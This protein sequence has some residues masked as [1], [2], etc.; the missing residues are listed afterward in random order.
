LKEAADAAD[1]AMEALTGF[2]RKNDY[3]GVAEISSA[4]RRVILRTVRRSLYGIQVGENTV[5]RQ[6]FAHGRA[7]A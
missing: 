6:E 4:M 2:G 3:L 1:R 7:R 5:A